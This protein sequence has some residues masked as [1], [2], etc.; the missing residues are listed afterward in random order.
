MP[1]PSSEAVK[2]ATDHL[3]GDKR[4]YTPN[5]YYLERLAIAFDSFAAAQVEA[6]VAAARAEMRERAAAVADLYT[7]SSADPES[8][9]VLDRIASYSNKTCLL[10]QQAIR[11]LP[12]DPEVTK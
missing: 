11:A 2:A 12:L 10:I 1:S 7:H 8:I 6:A 5:K 9:K 3:V 4:T